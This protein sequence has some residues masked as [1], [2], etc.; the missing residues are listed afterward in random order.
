MISFNSSKRDIALPN[1]GTMHLQADRK[2][3]IGIPPSASNCKSIKL[4]IQIAMEIIMSFFC[5]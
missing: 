2:C 3:S 4:K 1:I 5:K